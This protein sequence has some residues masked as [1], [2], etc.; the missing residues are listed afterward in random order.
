MENN[1]AMQQQWSKILL[2]AAVLGKYGYDKVVTMSQNEYQQSMNNFC[3][4]ILVNQT[5][6]EHR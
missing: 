6:M 3:I 5:G 4:G 1:G 2:S